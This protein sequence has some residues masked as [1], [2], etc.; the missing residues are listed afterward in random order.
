MTGE[1]AEVDLGLSEF[2]ASAYCSA[3]LEPRATASSSLMGARLFPMLFYYGLCNSDQ[4]SVCTS[5]FLVPLG[6]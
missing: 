5:F 3:R 2:W 4:S 6:I 1:G